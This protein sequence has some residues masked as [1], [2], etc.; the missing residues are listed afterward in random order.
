VKS[1]SWI[2]LLNDLSRTQQT[3]NTSNDPSALDPHATL[4]AQRSL[5]PHAPNEPHHDRSIFSAPFLSLPLLR[6]CHRS[7]A[8]Q[9]RRPFLAPLL[10]RC[11]RSLARWRLLFLLPHLLFLVRRWRDIGGPQ[12]RDIGGPWRWLKILRL[13]TGNSS[14]SEARGGGLRSEGRWR[15]LEIRRLAASSRLTSEA[16]GGASSKPGDAE[17]RRHDHE[18]GD[19]TGRVGE[20]DELTACLARRRGL[21]AGGLG[22]EDPIAF[23][24]SCRVLFGNLHIINYYYNSYSGVCVRRLFFLNA[25]V[26]WWRTCL[27][28]M[29][30][31]ISG[32]P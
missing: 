10:H 11:C 28:A 12:Q 19:V 16:H 24:F 7:L 20:A 9:S 1:F 31:L 4:V 15:W 23:H 25:L 14:T 5:D 8:Y 26:Y 13:T 21:V 18:H 2:T 30:R 17:M 22:V 6:Q 32:V 29:D 27:C 3:Q